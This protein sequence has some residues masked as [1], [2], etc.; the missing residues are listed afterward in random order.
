MPWSVYIYVYH[1]KKIGGKIEMKKLSTQYGV[2]ELLTEEE[3]RI[4]L[5]S[6]ALKNQEAIDVDLKYLRCELCGTETDTLINLKRKWLGSKFICRECYYISANASDSNL[7]EEELE[8]IENHL[9]YIRKHERYIHL[10]DKYGDQ[11]TEDI[12]EGI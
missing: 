12:T 2:K 9:K 4:K 1:I 10:N 8:Y 7:W 5:D 3:F 11:D 6:G